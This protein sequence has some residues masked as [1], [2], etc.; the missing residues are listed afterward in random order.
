MNEL[1][2]ESRNGQVE[3]RHVH[4]SGDVYC[5]D[6]AVLLRPVAEVLVHYL[7]GGCVKCLGSGESLGPG[8]P[9][10]RD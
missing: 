6:D 8:Q 1:N 4:C 5:V 3:G 10:K 9:R 2:V 7:Q